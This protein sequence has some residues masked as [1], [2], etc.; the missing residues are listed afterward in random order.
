VFYWDT[1]NQAHLDPLDERKSTSGGF[2]NVP[3]EQR[4]TIQGIR[5]KNPTKPQDTEEVIST[6]PSVVVAAGWTTVV[7]LYPLDFTNH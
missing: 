6:S 3:G 7:D 1:D 5:R 4:V 2:I